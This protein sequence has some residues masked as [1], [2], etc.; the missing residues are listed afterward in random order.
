MLKMNKFT[1]MILESDFRAI[2]ISIEILHIMTGTVPKSLPSPPQRCGISVHIS[3]GALSLGKILYLSP[4]SP[5]KLVNYKT[6][7]QILVGGEWMN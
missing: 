1:A 7:I 4:I 6:E 2:L 3:Y 5:N